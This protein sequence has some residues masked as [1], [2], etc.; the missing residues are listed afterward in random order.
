MKIS[1]TFRWQA[2]RNT[3]IP[4]FFPVKQGI[5]PGEWLGKTASTAIKSADQRMVELHAGFIAIY[6]GI[7]PGTYSPMAGLGGA[8]GN[9]FGLSR[10]FS[11]PPEIP[12]ELRDGMVAGFK[13]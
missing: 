3:K 9:S 6:R 7:L 5:A 4:C 12:V 1:D 11:P 8:V 2:A 10:V 13:T